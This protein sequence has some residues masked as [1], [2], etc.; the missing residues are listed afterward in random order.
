MDGLIGGRVGYSVAEGLFHIATKAEAGSP[1]G[2]VD[3]RLLQPFAGAL[4][5]EGVRVS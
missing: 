4:P 1:G 3:V 5:P 2:F